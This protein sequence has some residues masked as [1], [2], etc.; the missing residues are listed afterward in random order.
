MKGYMSVKEAAERWSLSVRWVN[1][2]AQDGRIPGCERLGKSWAIPENAIKPPRM[3]PG[4]KSKEAAGKYF[5]Y[6]EVSGP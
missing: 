2:Y 1:Q 5:F 4:V 6:Q 3:K